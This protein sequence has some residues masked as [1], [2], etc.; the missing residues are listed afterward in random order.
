MH[1][2]LDTVYIYLLAAK[3]NI[4]PCNVVSLFPSVNV[5][6]RTYGWKIVV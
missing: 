2:F 1:F 5:I 3:E 4:F 6:F